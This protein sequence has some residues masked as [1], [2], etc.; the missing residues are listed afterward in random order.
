MPY[1][2]VYIGKWH[3]DGSHPKIIDVTKEGKVFVP[4]RFRGGFQKWRGFELR[5]GPFDSYYIKDN[6]P[7]PIKIDGYQT[8]GLFQLAKD[9]IKQ[10]RDHNKPFFMMLSVE[11]PHPPFEVP[12]SYWKR[13]KDRKLILQPNFDAPVQH[14][15][16]GSKSADF[17]DD[18]RIYY[19]MIENLNDQIGQLME[20]VNHSGIRSNTIIVFL[21]DHGELLGSQGLREKQQPYEES[22]G[23]PFIISY[24]EGE[25]TSHRI[26]DEPTNSEDWY[27]TFRGLAGLNPDPDSPGMDLTPLLKGNLEKLPREGVLLEFVSEYREGAPFYSE[28]WR[29]VRTKRYKYTVKGEQTVGLPWQLFDLKEDPYEMNNL[30]ES[31]DYE[32]IARL[33]HEELRSELVRTDDHFIL[34]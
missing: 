15:L 32:D 19:A 18:M 27:P 14:K 3:L 31:S 33:L 8:E 7:T 13:W 30:I 17:M 2:T 26:V 22:V 21:S 20:E 25:I 1:E 11:P 10:E 9:Y 12:D 28:T 4:E 16:R 34:K 6:D 23:V 5:N 24:L 29:G